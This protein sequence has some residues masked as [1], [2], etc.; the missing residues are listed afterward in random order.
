[1][2]KMVAVLESLSG[3]LVGAVA[4][5]DRKKL[6]LSSGGFFF[7]VRTEKGGVALSY[8]EAVRGTAG[9]FVEI[10]ATSRPKAE[11]CELDLL[12]MSRFRDEEDLRVAVDYFDMEVKTSGLM[13]KKSMIRSYGGEKS[14][15]LKMDSP[16]FWK[17]LLGVLRSELL[18]SDLDR[19]ALSV[20]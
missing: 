8:A 2:S 6:Q 16:S 7:G 12:L 19:V 20:A 1:M 18:R 13:E 11:M 17:V 3:S 14:R 15:T 9:F 4:T 10:A 5:S